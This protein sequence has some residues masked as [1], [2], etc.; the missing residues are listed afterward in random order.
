MTVENHMLLLFFFYAYLYTAAG[1]GNWKA[2]NE[3]ISN[4]LVSSRLA[5]DVM[6][7]QNSRFKVVLGITVQP[8]SGHM[9]DFMSL[10]AVKIN[11]QNADTCTVLQTLLQRLHVRSNSHT[12]LWL[13]QT[14]HRY[15]F[16]I[17]Q[18]LPSLPFEVTSLC[19][20]AASGFLRI[21]KVYCPGLSDCEE[22]THC[23]YLHGHSQAPLSLNCKQINFFSCFLTTFYRCLTSAFF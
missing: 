16:F 19:K 7:L 9:G 1:W 4:P 13:M 18:I 11:L 22:R 3:W 14:S 20:S 6:N 2:Q 21:H 5:S 10:N 15:F 23:T 17:S 8:G 12:V